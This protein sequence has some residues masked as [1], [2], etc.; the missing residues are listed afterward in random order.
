VKDDK[1]IWASML[2]DKNA[3]FLAFLIIVAALA[4]AAVL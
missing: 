1:P 2:D 4:A 3:C